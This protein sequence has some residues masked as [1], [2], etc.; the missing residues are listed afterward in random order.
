MKERSTTEVIE[1]IVQVTEHRDRDVL[2][3]V[4]IGTLYELTGARRISL[5]KMTISDGVTGLRESARM[6]T[7]GFQSEQDGPPHGL[8]GFTALAGIP[9]FAECHAS[10]EARMEPAGSGVRYLHPVLNGNSMAGFLEVVSPVL[11]ETDK[12]L[13]DGFLKIYRNYLSVLDESEHDTLTGL[14]NRGA[15][16]KNLEKILLGKNTAAELVVLDERRKPLPNSMHWLA[17][18]DVDHF[19]RINDQH[20][21]LHGDEALMLLASIMRKVLR[22]SD[23]L[24]RFGGEEFVILLKPTD[25]ENARKVFERLRAAVESYPF[26]QIGKITVSIGFTR[27]GSHDTPSLV[28]GNADQA[29]YYAK[30]HGRNRVCSYEKLVEEGQLGSTE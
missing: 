1:S 21:H 18:V 2:E 16:D 8:K 27:I 30:E 22:G 10:G 17:V 23:K 24:F 11:G 15:F 13:I 20:G 19:K 29:L 25:F 12:K 4:M 3:T 26:P 14:L 7:E 9:D 6:D 5:Y 28:V